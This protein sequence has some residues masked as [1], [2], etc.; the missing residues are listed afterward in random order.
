MNTTAVQYIIIH[1]IYS[2][3]FAESWNDWKKKTINNAIALKAG[4]PFFIFLF[5]YSNPLREIFFPSLGIYI[6][7]QFLVFTTNL[8]WCT[9]QCAVHTVNIYIYVRTPRLQCWIQNTISIR[10]PTQNFCRARIISRVP[11]GNFPRSFSCIPVFP[12]R[13]FSFILYYRRSFIYFSRFQPHFYANR[14][15]RIRDGGFSG[16]PFLYNDYDQYD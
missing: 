1:S 4:A 12:S 16:F 15:D 8:Q 11:S 3:C 2:Y 6:K 9:R 14:S 5:L 7:Q 13:L 10:P